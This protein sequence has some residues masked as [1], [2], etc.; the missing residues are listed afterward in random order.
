MKNFL[1]NL[2]GFNHLQEA[3]NILSNKIADLESNLK[4]ELSDDLNYDM[5]RQVEQQVEREVD[6][7][8]Y[9]Y[10]FEEMKDKID[11]LEDE[12]SG[13]DNRIVGCQERLEAL[14]DKIDTLGIFDRLS[15]LE[16]KLND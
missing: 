5:E 11:N 16:E 1:R 10:D 13:F 12:S 7:R 3:N 2:I 8:L 14:S 9:N 6:D 4:E 15:A